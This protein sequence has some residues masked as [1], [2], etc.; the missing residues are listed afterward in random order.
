MGASGFAWQGVTSWL[1]PPQVTPSFVHLG[2]VT[3][4]MGRVLR[5]LGPASLGER[6][7]W[8]EEW[9]WEDLV[10]LQRR[11]PLRRVLQRTAGT[12]RAVSASPGPR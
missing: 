10:L 5:S 3:V 4:M 11:C 8:A 7:P 12:F 6:E 9:L 2:K 1:P